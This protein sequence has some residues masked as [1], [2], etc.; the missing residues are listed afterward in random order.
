MAEAIEILQKESG[1]EVKFHTNFQPCKGQFGAAVEALKVAY[2]EAARQLAP[3]NEVHEESQ[4]KISWGWDVSFQQEA[5]DCATT[6]PEVT[7]TLRTPSPLPDLNNGPDPGEFRERWR[8]G[9][10]GCSV[11]IKNR[12]VR[13]SHQYSHGKDNYKCAL[14]NWEFDHFDADTWE[15]VYVIK[16]NLEYIVM[17]NEAQ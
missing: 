1:F 2:E 15:W 11:S 8:D 6:W 4:P 10:A 12:K 5:N 14:N 9:I 16:V 13:V 7:C 17:E 3:I